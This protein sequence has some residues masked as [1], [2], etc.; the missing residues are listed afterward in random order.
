MFNDVA[1]QSN[2]ISKVTK[3]YEESSF[4]DQVDSDVSMAVP[5]RNQELNLASPDPN[6][7]LKVPE[8][9]SEP[10]SH[11]LEI[12]PASSPCSVRI[13]SVDEAATDDEESRLGIVDEQ[14]KEG[15]P[16]TTIERDYSI[17]EEKET[18]SNLIHRKKTLHVLITEKNYHTLRLSV[19]WSVSLLIVM[20]F[21]YTVSRFLS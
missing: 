16:E 12:D 17:I 10:N 6:F 2:Q 3:N 13:R 1:E 19:S 14:T 20:L 8:I 21:V 18:Y 5:T 9:T 15:F 7:Y 4:E 11:V